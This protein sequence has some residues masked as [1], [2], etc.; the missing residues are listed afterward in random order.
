MKILSKKD[1]LIHIFYKVTE[2]IGHTGYVKAM[3]KK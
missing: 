1:N 3:G 2:M